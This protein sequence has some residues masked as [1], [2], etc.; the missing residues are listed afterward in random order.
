MSSAR[1]YKG[2]LR[3]G[4]KNYPMEALLIE[5]D[6]GIFLSDLR[7]HCRH[8]DREIYYP[9]GMSCLKYSQSAL[10]HVQPTTT[11]L[12]TS[13]LPNKSGCGSFLGGI[14]SNEAPED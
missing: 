7:S 4:K 9:Y 3:F 12:T 6:I 8:S 1:E 14:I 5:K 2:R 13:N 10:V 11:N